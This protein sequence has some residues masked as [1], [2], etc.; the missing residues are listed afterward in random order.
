MPAKKRVKAPAP[1]PIP[2]HA[3]AAALDP[4]RKT[5]G[6]QVTIPRADAVAD[7]KAWVD[8]NEK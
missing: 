5:G 3:T 6:A 1:A 8:E 4:A 2:L 7:A